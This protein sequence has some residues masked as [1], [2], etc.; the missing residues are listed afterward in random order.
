M[1]NIRQSAVAGLFYPASTTELTTIVDT[2]LNNTTPTDIKPKAII[3]PHAGYIYSGQ[4]AAQAY[5]ALIPLKNKIKRIIL[6]G[7][8]HRVP[9]YGCALSGADYFETPLGKIAIDQKAN[10]E[11]IELN[12][13]KE[14]N[15][16][17]ALE[18][19]LEV[20]LP[21]LQRVL[22]D[23]TL[24][25]VVVGEASPEEVSRL[26]EHFWDDDENFFVI[27]SDL[28]HY[29]PYAEAQQ[30]DARTSEAIIHFDID[31]IHSEQACGCRPVNGLLNLAKKHHMSACVLDQKN[32]GDT[33]GDKDQVVGYGAYAVY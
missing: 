10:A 21:F 17:H 4:V 7:P 14:L 25:P 29:H 16:A 26:I 12:L 22:S 27:S 33:A 20:H 11:L 31:H 32:S 15:E 6:L 13:A 5:R 18:H 8:S 23:F 30:L 1:S 9:F 19:S 24:V 2:Y 28:S 3:A